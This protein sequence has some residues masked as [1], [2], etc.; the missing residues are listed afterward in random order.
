MSPGMVS[1]D[2]PYED[3][4]HARIFSGGGGMV[5]TMADYVSRSLPLS[6]LTLCRSLPPAAPRVDDLNLIDHARCRRLGSACASPT[7]ASLTAHGSS[8]ARPATGCAATT[9]QAARTWARWRG[10]PRAPASALALVSTTR[11]CSAGSEGLT[12]MSGDLR[13]SDA[14]DSPSS[15]APKRPA[16]SSAKARTAGEA[17]RQRTFG[18]IRRR[19]WWSS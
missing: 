17:R 4:D 14:Q 2:E 19:T 3:G 15:K 8:P 13:L 1:P 5:G 10:I 6:S 11:H 16:T 18:S 12:L 7:A 9:Y